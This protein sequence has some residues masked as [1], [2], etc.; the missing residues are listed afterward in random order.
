VMLDREAIEKHLIPLEEML[1]I[2]K[3]SDPD[4][5]LLECMIQTSKMALKYLECIKLLERI[6]TI[7]E[8]GNIDKNN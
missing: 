6:V 2:T 7:I 8:N 4:Y 5:P 1:E 3:Q